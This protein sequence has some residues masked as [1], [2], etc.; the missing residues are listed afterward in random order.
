MA[1]DFIHE[2]PFHEGFRVRGLLFPVVADL[3]AF[4]VEEFA[5]R[6]TEAVRFPR[7]SRGGCHCGKAQRFLSAMT[8]SP[9]Q[10][11]RTVFTAQRM[12]SFFIG[13]QVFTRPEFVHAH[14]QGPE[15]GVHPGSPLGR[16]SRV[17]GE[18]T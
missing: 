17:G 11:V 1:G 18:E 14:E 13:F 2:F 3:A 10:S 4:E 12:D 5:E 7:L 16:F 6:G 8:S 9:E 15:G